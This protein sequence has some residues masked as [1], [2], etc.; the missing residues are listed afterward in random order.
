MTPKS[1][2]KLL[3]TLSL[4]QSKQSFKGEERIKT[5]SN[6]QELKKQTNKRNTLPYTFSQKAIGGCAPPKQGSKSR[7]KKTQDLEKNGT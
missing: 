3:T 2:G 7:K 5:F 1:K 4:N 6:I